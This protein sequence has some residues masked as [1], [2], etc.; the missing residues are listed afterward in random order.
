MDHILLIVAAVSF[1]LATIGVGARINLV[2]FGLLC[3]T[4][5]QLV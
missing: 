2:A 3:L 1:A 4:L 5:A